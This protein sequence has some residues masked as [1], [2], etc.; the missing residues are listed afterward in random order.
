MYFQW[1]SPAIQPVKATLVLRGERNR[2][3]QAAQRAELLLAQ[4]VPGSPTRAAFARV[5]VVKPWV[6]WKID[7]SPF[8]DGTA[9]H[10]PQPARGLLSAIFRSLL[11]RSFG[12]F[13]GL[14]PS[15]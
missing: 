8:R 15:T 2:S 5:G 1:I 11:S 7:P 9:L 6:K 10:T 3:N 14:Q 13:T 4:D 12:Y